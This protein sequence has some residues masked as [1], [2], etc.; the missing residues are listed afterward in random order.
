MIDIEKLAIALHNNMILCEVIE[1][2]GKIIKELFTLSSSIFSDKECTISDSVVQK[3]TKAFKNTAEALDFIDFLNNKMKDYKNVLE[4]DKEIND[5][6]DT[7]E[8]DTAET[9]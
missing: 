8:T 4:S 7:T 5:G 6:T 9:N 3:A 2:Q 1:T